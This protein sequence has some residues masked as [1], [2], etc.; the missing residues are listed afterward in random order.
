[1]EYY[2]AI[3]ENELLPFVITW[4]DLVCITL[5]EISQRK[6][7]TTCSHLWSLKNKTNRTK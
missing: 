2:S 5:S 4:V 7:N 1:M 3:K 6:T